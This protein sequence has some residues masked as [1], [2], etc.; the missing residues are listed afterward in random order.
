MQKCRKIR[1][2]SRPAGALEIQACESISQSQPITGGARRAKS[3]PLTRTETQWAQERRSESALPT[4][5]GNLDGTLIGAHFRSQI[6]YSIGPF[7][8]VK[9]H[10]FWYLKRDERAA[11]RQGDWFIE[12]AGS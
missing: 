5:I 11:A 2:L 7:R 4:I 3:G 9:P 8:R 10:L 12:L 6:L 1:V